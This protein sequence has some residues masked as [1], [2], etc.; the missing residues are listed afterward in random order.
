[1]DSLNADNDKINDL[2]RKNKMLVDIRKLV[3]E[4]VMLS[5]RYECLKEKPTKYFFI[6]ENRQFTN[7]VMNKTI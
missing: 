5:A 4:G 1:M 6:L 2:V 3:I 7:T